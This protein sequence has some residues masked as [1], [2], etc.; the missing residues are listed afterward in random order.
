MKSRQFISPSVKKQPFA[1]PF[2]FQ[3]FAAHW[4]HQVPPSYD[5]WELAARYEIDYLEQYCRNAA[6]RQADDILTRG[7]GLA[8][9]VKRG[10][11]LYM[12]DKILR[13]LFT[14]REMVIQ[15]DYKGGKVP[16]LS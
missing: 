4:V 15:T 8:Y 3:I 12:L 1:N 13:A 6:R 7:E 2:S 10:V 14:A 11:P 5:L 16:Y 9:F